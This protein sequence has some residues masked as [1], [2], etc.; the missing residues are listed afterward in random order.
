[1]DESSQIRE[2]PGS[3]EEEGIRKYIFRLRSGSLGEEFF[4]FP[5]HSSSLPFPFFETMVNCASCST[6]LQPNAKFCHGCGKPVAAASSPAL[7]PSSFKP[8]PTTATTPAATTSP[9]RSPSYG[10]ARTTTATT[11]PASSPYKAPMSAAAA[12]QP[13]WGSKAASPAAS[14]ASPTPTSG[15]LSPG[16]FGAP[17]RGPAPTSAASTTST[18]STFAARQ[19]AEKKAAE[20]KR[21]AE[22]KAAEEK[23]AAD[24]RADGERKAAEQKA[25]ADRARHEAERKA[26]EQKAAA[27]SARQEADKKAAEQKVAEQKAAEQKAAEQKAAADRARQEAEQKAK[28]DAEAERARRAHM[29]S[30]SSPAVVVRP[31]ASQPVIS[32]GPVVRAGPADFRKPGGLA[33]PARGAKRHSKIDMD[34][35]EIQPSLA[36]LD[37]EG[38]QVHHEKPVAAV[39]EAPAPSSPAG[40]ASSGGLAGGGR[41]SGLGN[42][43]AQMMTEKAEAEKLAERQKI[44]GR[45]KGATEFVDKQIR[46]LISILQG[47]G[48]SVL[49]GDLF[50]ETADEMPALAATLAVAQKRGVLGFEGN[51]LM[52][53][54]H[55]KVRITLL[56][57]EIEGSTVFV[58]VYGIAPVSSE[59]SGP[60]VETCAVCNKVV[61]PTERV[62]ASGKT[63]HKTCFRCC[64]CSCVL[65]LAQYAFNGGKF[66]CEPHFKEAFAAGGGKY[67]F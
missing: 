17:T 47:K 33:V 8:A 57:S 12:R 16:R 46:M 61:Y 49:F 56:K 3:G 48:G 21:A 60:K 36:G 38:I 1:M 35:S 14:P 50:R 63:L 22:L 43:F 18:T 24:H 26:A 19:E 44:R 5:A 6:T 62:A 52:Q 65:K 25:A 55:D 51:M 64:H 23:R 29:A 34:T 9:L 53:G 66:Y 28:A 41:P 15:G 54:V 67:N 42:R 58:S 30:A 27:D 32:R 2:Q 13:A 10:A 39:R 11:S 59:M 7:S 31:A 20:E 45:R 37:V 4:D 40:P